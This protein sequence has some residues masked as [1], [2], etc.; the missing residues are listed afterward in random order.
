MPHARLYCLVF[1]TLAMSCRTPRSPALPAPA[2]APIVVL[3]SG[4]RV[5]L[6]VRSNGIVTGRLLVSVNSSTQWL[7]VCIER[8]LPCDSPPGFRAE[9]LALAAIERLEV[10]TKA[11]GLSAQFGLYLGGFIGALLHPPDKSEDIGPM[12]LGFVVG[13]AV[14]AAVG[15][16]FEAWIPA[17]PCSPHVCYTRPRR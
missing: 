14:G 8:T 10:R 4:V 9:S 15:S 6:H 7:V 2:Q 5:R 11:T 17:F 13:A 3:D 12:F 16:R 1:L